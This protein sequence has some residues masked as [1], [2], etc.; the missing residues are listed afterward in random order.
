MP[1]L[2]H[3]NINTPI[4][5]KIQRIYVDTTIIVIADIIDITGSFLVQDNMLEHK[6]EM[7][8]KDR[9]ISAYINQR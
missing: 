7:K 9:N 5:N 4:F 3:K 2:K 6:Q 8:V 1:T